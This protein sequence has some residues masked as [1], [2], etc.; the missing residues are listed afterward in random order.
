M[1]EP[2]RCEVAFSG[3]RSAAG[4]ATC[5][6]RHMWNLIQRR[7]PD[8]AF[9]HQLHRVVLPRGSAWPGVCQVLGELVSRH[10]SLRT[11]YRVG[12]DGALRQQVIRSGSFSVEALPAADAPDAGDIVAEWEAGA[13]RGAFDHSVDLPFRAAIVCHDGEP[14]HGVL[15]VSHMAADLTGLRVLEAEITRL[16]AAQVRGVTAGPPPLLR[17]PLEQAAF[18]E[19]ARG[20]RLLARADRHWD[21]QLAAMPSTMFPGAATV[22]EDALPP[23]YSAVLTSRAVALALPV[24]AERHRTSGST[25]LL[26]VVALLL[27]RRAGLPRCALRLLTANRTDPEL[28]GTVANLH[29]EVLA[30]VDTDGKTV[31]DVMRSARVAALRAYANGLY[32]P[33]RAER[34]AEKH[35]RER[36]ER[37][38]LSCCFN[39]ARSIREDRPPTRRRATPADIRKATAESRIEHDGELHEAE[40]FFL[41]IHDDVPDRVRIILGADPRV[42]PPEAVR[43][44]LAAVEQL[45]VSFAADEVA[46]MEPTTVAG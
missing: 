15:F 22:P 18:E 19:S 34:L 43:A 37:I 36:G 28:R 14:V 9:Y 24:L 45:L 23:F 7:M 4:P 38:D 21:D 17:Q 32:D 5:A 29:Q 12:G 26:A 39:D 6:Q 41:V 20:R 40:R 25:V 13:R 46:F 35:E 11:V 33:G 16:L 31:A 10:E 42:L 8:S 44:F 3:G 27:A 1:A 30:V 2:I